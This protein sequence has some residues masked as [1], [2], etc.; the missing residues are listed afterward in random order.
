MTASPVRYVNEEGVGIITVDNP[1]LNV[2]SRAVRDGL[3][4]AVREAAADRSANAVV[5]AGAGKSFTAGA[6]IKEFGSTFQGADINAICAALE[7]MRKPVV[8]ALH[9][10]P[11]GGGVELALACHY[12]IAT[13]D[14]R[15]GLPEVKLGLLPGG[16][17]TQRLPRL[18]GAKFALDFITSGDPVTAAAAKQAGFI[19]E[20]ADGDILAAAIALAKSKL[21][22][23]PPKTR[24]RTDQ[25]EAGRAHSSS[26]RSAMRSRSASRPSM[27]RCAAWIRSKT[28]SI[29]PSTRA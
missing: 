8:A 1:P 20:I 28:L 23:V 3:L 4:L 13:A 6:D 25:I 10:T 12:R 22:S 5:L 24:E 21:G 29:F 9:G 17:G 19:D 15:L 14:A 7:D 27:R 18:T 2:L 11:L 26:T 16:G